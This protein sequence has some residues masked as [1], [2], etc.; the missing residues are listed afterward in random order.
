[1]TISSSALINNNCSNNRLMRFEQLWF[2]CCAVANL[3]KSVDQVQFAQSWFGQLTISHLFIY[4][5]ICLF[6]ICWY[7]FIYLKICLVFICWYLFIYLKIFF[8]FV[9]LYYCHS[10]GDGNQVD[11]VILD[12]RDH[13][14]RTTLKTY[15]ISY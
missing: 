7:L 5:K 10:S 13:F 11:D 9:N 4:L 3:I 8:F 14:V 1:M 6:C 15:S 12:E 2:F